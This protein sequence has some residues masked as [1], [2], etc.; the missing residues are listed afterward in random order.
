MT[1]PPG[2]SAAVSG[3]SPQ[4]VALV[5][6]GGA[7]S[8]L[9]GVDKPALRID[10]RSLLDRALDAVAPARTVV[11]GPARELPDYVGQVREDP[12]GSGPAAAIAAGLRFADPLPGSRVA[13]LAADLPAISRV[14]MAWLAIAL[15]TDPDRADGA[16][17]VDRQ[18]RRQH[19]VSLWHEAALRRAVR[20]RPSW[21]NAGVGRLLAP[22]RVIEVP[23]E[24]GFAADIDTRTDLSRWPVDS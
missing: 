15:G 5:L 7:G 17:L 20:G 8:R 16:V 4:D 6:A 23:D 18:G 24:G 22:L 13:V 12:P 11:V 2:P 3:L 19:L 1:E 10:G 14:G 21:V 9:G